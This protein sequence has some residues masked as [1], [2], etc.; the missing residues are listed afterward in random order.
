MDQRV[1]ERLK[2]AVVLV[3]VGLFSACSKARI[4]TEI[5]GGDNWTRTVTLSGPEKKEGGMNMAP[6]VEESFVLP[7]AKDG[8][9]LHEDKKDADRTLTFEKTLAIGASLKGDLSIRGA[10]PA[11]MNLVNEVTVSRVAP[12]RFEYRETLRWTGPKPEMLSFKLEDLAQ[13]KAVLPKP[14]A[15]DANARAVMEKTSVLSV[16]L[17]FGP[18][19]PLLAIGLIHPDLAARRMSQRVGGVLLKAL[20]EQFGDKM[21]LPERREVARQII[22][23]TF[24]KTKPSQPDPA[25]PPSNKK[26]SG[27]VPL[28]FI[29][30]SPGKVISTNGEV[31][32]L[33]GEIYW[34]MF[35]EAAS[36]QPVVLT[37]ILQIDPR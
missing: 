1:R 13:L 2:V 5:K 30:K 37:V 4:T 15:T 16:P 29:V 17:L 23:A 21:S 34:A 32:D 22:E 7:A 24:A 25:A 27:L 28:M 6:S 20:E 31:D 3:V 19:D 10:D 26:D 9:K 33:N 35:P 18:G 14:L 12:R 11:Q 36:F 8:W